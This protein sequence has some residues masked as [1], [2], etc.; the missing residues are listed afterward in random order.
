VAAARTLK[1]PRII[2]PCPHETA[3]WRRASAAGGYR[4][5]CVRCNELRGVRAE[6]ETAPPSSLHVQF[7]RADGTYGPFDPKGW[8]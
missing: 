4:L 5:R 1:A 6:T 7:K 8:T 3:T 2:A